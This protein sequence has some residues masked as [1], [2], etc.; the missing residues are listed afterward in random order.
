MWSDVQESEP[1]AS[2]LDLPENGWGALS[3]RSSCGR[4]SR[5]VSAISMRRTFDQPIRRPE[6]GRWG[7]WADRTWSDLGESARSWPGSP[8]A[9]V[10]GASR[11][12]GAYPAAHLS[13]S[14][15]GK[16]ADRPGTSAMISN[17]GYSAWKL[18]VFVPLVQVK[19][20]CV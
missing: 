20:S 8:M 19:V 15:P 12:F 10:Q 4:S 6:N 5:L 14:G 1:S 9:A 7:S 18:S 2:W 11:G 13:P 3:I 16:E 17:R